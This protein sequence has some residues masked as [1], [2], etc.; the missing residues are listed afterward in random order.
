MLQLIRSEPAL[1]RCLVTWHG[2]GLNG[3]NIDEGLNVTN[4]VVTFAEGQI[5]EE[6]YV[7]VVADSDPETKESYKIILDQVETTGMLLPQI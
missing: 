1:G 7:H 2:V 4:G 6:I 5:S 3:Y